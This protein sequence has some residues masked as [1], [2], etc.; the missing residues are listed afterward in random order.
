MFSTVTL[1]LWLFV[2]IVLFA[3]VTFASHFLFPSVRWFFRRRLERAV[4]ELNKRLERPIEPFKLARRFDTVQRLVYDAEVLA[5]VS[6][7][8]AA[9]GIP[10][11]VAHER[12]RRHAREIVPAFSA[13]TYFGVAARLT[14]L[15]SRALYDIRVDGRADLA[16]VPRDAT[17]VF[18][19]N[20]RSN[21]DYVLV[22]WLVADRTALSYA[23]G[24]W[25]RV[26]PLS[27]LIRGMGAYFIRRRRVSPLYRTVLRRYVAMATAAGTT[28]AVFPEGGLSLDGRLQPPRLGILSWIVEAAEAE[29]REVVFVPVA[30]AYDRVLE[31]RVLVQAA[32]SGDRRFRASW[33][34]LMRFAARMLWRKLRG[35]WHGFGTAAVSFGAPLALSAF[36]AD[37]GA[38]TPRLLGRAL[39]TRIERALPAL[40]VPILARAILAADGPVSR[41][42]LARHLGDM[43]PGSLDRGL[44]ILLGRQLVT[45]TPAGLVATPSERGLL[46]FYAAALPQDAAA[47][48][49][50]PD[51]PLSPEPVRDQGVASDETRLRDI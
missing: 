28:Q 2:L 38:A 49:D 27:R 10:E 30:L 43:P 48:P 11:A 13:F 39:M 1:P 37:H 14:R 7:T 32:G 46:A 40:P 3:G 12:A 20:H 50:D 19:M 47:Q 24:E 8:A 21:M 36:R 31:D 4:E 18:V 35:R 16:A 6:A 33:P 22:T 51:A 44:S 5:A 26:W 23:V 25:A 42:D 15:V 41:A 34:A 29:G 9:Q 17:V 45:D